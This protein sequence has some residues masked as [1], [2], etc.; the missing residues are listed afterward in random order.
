MEFSIFYFWSCCREN[1][2]DSCK[3]E[4]RSQCKY[5]ITNKCY[6]DPNDNIL[7]TIAHFS[8]SPFINPSITAINAVI[9]NFFV[10]IT[11]LL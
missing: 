4:E 9:R 2:I 8:N 3:Q 6:Y 11:S 10:F 5:T 1:K 7:F